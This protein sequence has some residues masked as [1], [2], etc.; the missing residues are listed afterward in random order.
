M[1]NNLFTYGTSELTHDAVISWIL[2][3]GNNPD[4][5]LY[6]LAKDFINLLTNGKNEFNHL[7]IRRQHHHI[8]I[9]I[10]VDD[11]TVIVIEDKIEALQT[12]N[13][14]KN[15]KELVDEKYS[16]KKIFYNYITVG[17]ESSY[18]SIQEEDYTVIERKDLIEL[19]K[20]YTENSEIISYYHEYLKNIEEEYNSYQNTEI[21]DWSYRSW[22]GFY[23]HLQFEKQEG[24]WTYVSNPRGGFHA[25][26]WKGKD[27]KFKD[28][29]GFTVYLQIEQSEKVAVKV[30]V[31]D[32]NY[33]SEIRNYLW[34]LV[35]DKKSSKSNVSKP[36]FGKGIHMTF[37]EI[38]GYDTI[39]ELNN[40]IKEAEN[41]IALI[42]E[43][44]N[45]SE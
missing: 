3:W 9:F 21:A 45:Y 2:S 22:Q 36:S 18:D 32:P 17:D 27:F 30:R 19:V 13:Q 25:F 37:A 23:K 14:L 16:D 5:P 7:V 1:K 24:S 35:K 10:E 31:E 38:R 34:N 43:H 11:D 4:E 26:Y 44:H 20:H 41:V 29:I 39:A 33:Q 15:Y 28:D 42:S 12:G 6:K 40:A 8:D